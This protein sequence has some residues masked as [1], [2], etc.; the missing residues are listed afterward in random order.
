MMDYHKFELRNEYSELITEFR[1]H[2]VP[3]VGECVFLRG[4]NAGFRVI[5]VHHN[6]SEKRII[7]FTDDKEGIP[8]PSRSPRLRR[9]DHERRET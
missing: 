2:T 1:W 3:R 7:V 5:D 6:V 4:R 8:V 9:F